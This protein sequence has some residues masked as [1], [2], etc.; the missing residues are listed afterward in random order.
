MP[1]YTAGQMNLSKRVLVAGKWRYWP[2][3]LSSNGRIK[4]DWQLHTEGAFTGRP[5]MTRG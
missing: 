3:V 5:G 1:V 4:Q 2:L